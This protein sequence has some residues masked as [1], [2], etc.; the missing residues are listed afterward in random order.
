MNAIGSG[1]GISSRG[2]RGMVRLLRAVF[3]CLNFACHN[4]LLLSLED[5]ESN[6]HCKGCTSFARCDPLRLRTSSPWH[7]SLPRGAAG[8]IRSKCVSPVHV[9]VLPSSGLCRT[10]ASDAWPHQA[11]SI[12]SRPGH[13]CPLNFGC[14]DRDTSKCLRATGRVSS[15]ANHGANNVVRGS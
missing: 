7:H 1:R 4:S 11:S 2:S 6:H 13:C 12:V 8:K 5:S 3:I 9:N 10:D 15:S 14:V